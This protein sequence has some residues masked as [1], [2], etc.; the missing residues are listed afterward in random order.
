MSTDLSQRSPSPAVGAAPRLTSLPHTKV[1]IDDAFWSERQRVN[2]ERT[3]AHIYEQCRKTGRI[4]A[5]RGIYDPELVRRGVL[6]GNIPILFWDSDL[7]K[8]LEAASYSLATHPDAELDALVDE[9]IAVLARAQ[10]PDGY[11]NSWFTFVEPQKRWSNLRDWHELYDAGHLIEAAVAHFEA[12]GKRSLLDVMIRY[13]DYIASVFG[14]GA[15]QRR[16]Y[17]GHPEIELALLRLAR[18]SGEGRFL[19][20]ARYFVDERGRQPHYFD[21]EAL[22]RGDDPAKYWFKNYEYSQSH[23]PV[24]EQSEVVGHAVRAAYLYSAMADLAAE[25]GDGELLAVC[26][27][28]WQHL[29]SRRMYVMGGIGTS[30]QNEGF[31]SDY[32]LP[33]ESAYAETCAAIALVFWAQRMLALDLDRRYAD[34]MELALYN[35]V[36]SGVSADG[37]HFFYDNPLASNGGHHREEWFHCPCC[38]PNLSRIVASIGGYFY[39]QGAD[40]AVVHLYGQSTATL[41]LAGQEVTL[42]QETSYPWDGAVRITVG[43]AAPVAFGLRLR[44]PAWCQAPRLAVNGDEVDLAA[45]T[46]GGYALVS[47]TWQ[48]GDVV[49]L[50]LPMPVERLYAHPAVVADVAS[51]ALRRGPIVY[52]LEQ[53]D[54]AAPVRQLLLPAGAELVA[55]FDPELL[56]GVTVVEGQGVA[57][58]ERGWEETLYRPSPPEAEPCA[59]RAIPYF[60]WD[61]R[62]PGPMTV[63]VPE[64]PAGSSTLAR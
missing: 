5:L 24:R 33:N 36:I 1:T 13:A 22:A 52:C 39:A 15:G 35:A 28:L 56:G 3:I 17:C 8:W 47:R 49:T 34:V 51:V 63:W 48:D 53:A 18:A 20:L 32:D 64:Q 16:G 23:L 43:A 14:R 55:R 25:D 30:R 27:R 45:A 10:Q 26:R 9:V 11:L 31:T 21:Q 44:L 2:R 58:A 50:E 54:H 57:L 12:T 19:E 40:E 59:I 46:T 29:T 61:N 38:P 42:R 37:S 7:A 6:G 60:A 4:D 62:A 41:R